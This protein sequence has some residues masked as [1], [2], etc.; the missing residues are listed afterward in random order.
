MG[1]TTTP[2]GVQI[3]ATTVNGTPVTYNFATATAAAAAATRTRKTS[4]PPR[5]ATTAAGK[6]VP[7]GRFA[8]TAHLDRLYISSG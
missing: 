3:R 1:N 4:T 7:G 6:I 5:T 8:T 2:E